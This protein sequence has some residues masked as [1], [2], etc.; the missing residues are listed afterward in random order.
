MQAVMNNL[1]GGDMHTETPI[2][3]PGRRRFL[4]KGLPVFG[5]CCFGGLNTLSGVNPAAK[6]IFD[7]TKHKFLKDSGMSYKQV[8]DFAFNRR[9]I[10]SMK[11]FGELM[12]KEKF[13]EMLAQAS[14]DAATKA[15][16]EHGQR[17][18]P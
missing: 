14:A 4:I 2:F 5:M 12:G 9:F 16:K 15:T 18:S 6:T 17:R 10:E 1:G 11:I 7:E 3:Q 8:F 13:L